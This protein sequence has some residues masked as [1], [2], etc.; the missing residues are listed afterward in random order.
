MKKEDWAKAKGKDGKWKKGYDSPRKRDTLSPDSEWNER[1]LNHKSNE[2]RLMVSGSELTFLDRGK[3]FNEFKEKSGL[4]DSAIA[5]LFEKDRATISREIRLYLK[6]EEYGINK[7]THP[8]TPDRIMMRALELQ[9]P[10]DSKNFIKYF[11]M[12]PEIEFS[13]LVSIINGTLPIPKYR[14]ELTKKYE[15]ELDAL[16]RL[17]IMLNKGTFTTL[18][19]KTKTKK[20]QDEDKVRVVNGMIVE[21]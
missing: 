17:E 7:K 12:F 6:S 21:D 13:K 19:S 9:K 1:I 8:K 18:K 5:K 20:D 16:E 11:E 10:E 14:K 3:I 15:A 2:I 4:S